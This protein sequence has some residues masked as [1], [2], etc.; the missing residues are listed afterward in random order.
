MPLRHE[1]SIIF[2]VVVLTVLGAWAYTAIPASIFPTMSFA[3]VDV[4]A[5]AGDL[6]PDRVRI[7]VAQPLERA[8]TGLP[9][10]TRV[11][12]TSAQGNAEL[13]VEFDPHTDVNTDLQQVFQGISSARAGL[14]A[15]TNVDATII[16]PNSEPILSYAFVSSELSQTVVHEMLAQ[17]LV[18][19][20]Y[21]IPGLARM[22]VVGGPQREYAVQLDAGAL[23]TR[24]LSAADVTKALGEANTVVSPGIVNSYAQRNIIVVDSRLTSA[25][26]LG[27]VAIPLGAHDSVPLRALGSVKLGVAP[28]TDQMSFDANHAV[29]INFFALPGADAV[30]MADAVDARMA[31]FAPRLPGGIAVHKYWDQT[32]LVRD[33]QKSLRDAI[34]IGAVLAILVIL[35]FLRNLRM[36]LIAALII[37]IAVATVIFAI[38]RFGQ[39]LNLMS[40]GGLAVAVGLIIDDAIVVI[41]NVARHLH[42]RPR[43]SG[44]SARQ[45]SRRVVPE[46]M[47]ELIAPMTAS[48]ITTVVV[49]V[50]LA[51]LSGVSGFFFRAL[52]ITLAAS[53]VV[54][55]LLAIFVTPIVASVLVKPAAE[56]HDNGGFTGAILARYEPL[57]R[58]A[59]AHRTAVYV[60]S[61]VVLVV[62]VLLLTHLPSDFLPSLDEGQFEIGYRMP[63]GTTLEESDAAGTQ[64]EKVALSD[65]AVASVGRFTGIDTNGFSPTPP[66]TGTIRVTLKPKNQRAGYDDVSG[67][68]RD[69]MQ[70]AVPAAELDFHQILEDMI[71]DMSGA[72]SPIELTLNGPDQSTLIASAKDVADRLG[73]LQGVT[74]VYSGVNY[75]DP[76]IRIAPNGSRLAALGMG[77]TDIAD[78]L[79]A[80]TL[81]NVATQVSGG[82]QLVPVRVVV[83]DA[84]APLDRRLLPTGAGAMPLNSLAS[85]SNDRASSD[86][87]E[88]NGAR[89]DIVTANY[90]G[91]SLSAVID[92]IRGAMNR[93]HCRPGIRGR[94]A[95][96]TRR[97]NRRFVNLQ[98]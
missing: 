83:G 54:S 33:S 91:K 77:V 22:L 90:S 2:L 78:A 87:V 64:L 30:K 63:V 81:G 44:E 34:G 68:M 92:E 65:P 43:A 24:G 70:G 50:P 25:Q 76:A 75:D 11:R 19:Q 32:T 7:A 18:P 84:S 45:A 60:A 1:R 10:V 79:G 62:T 53:L 37:P 36:T 27:E 95:A 28:L 73:R 93:R 39:T 59:L 98:R 74:D 96:S 61:A 16:N 26:A 67:R 31:Q 47:R 58:W 20:F 42:E 55:L 23:S 38:G 66:R 13:I 52:A 14:P 86:I 35:L 94:S 80:A 4:V 72:P 8:F 57:L 51:L 48:T 89:I 29:A 21:G 17:N 56:P 71:N 88:Q 9:S 69:T 3:R 46:A 41:E 6:P 5:G 12:S 15:G 40:V 49:F 97:N 85:T 82:T